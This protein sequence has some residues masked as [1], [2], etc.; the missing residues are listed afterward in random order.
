M[1]EPERAAALVLVCALPYL[2]PALELVDV[3][4]LAVEL[5]R[6]AG[7]PGNRTLISPRLMMTGLGVRLGRSGSEKE[8]R[9]RGGWRLG[10]VVEGILERWEGRVAE[11]G[12]ADGNGS[13]RGVLTSRTSLTL[14]GDAHR[15]EL[16]AVCH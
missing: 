10:L 9:R 4:L 7:L 5:V 16:M 1:E 11:A 2:Q 14:V 12:D 6:V 3:G 15:P 8:T 13:R